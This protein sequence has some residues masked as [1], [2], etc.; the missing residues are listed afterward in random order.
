MADMSAPASLQWERFCRGPILDANGFKV[1]GDYHDRAWTA[2]YPA[3][4]R[5][6]IREDDPRSIAA[7][8]WDSAA[9]V[10]ACR[11]EPG[12]VCGMVKLNEA[13]KPRT[14]CSW[15]R[16]SEQRGAGGSSRGFWEWRTALGPEGAFVS[17]STSF[18]VLTRFAKEELPHLPTRVEPFTVL[19]SAA[20]TKVN[21]DD[22]QFWLLAFLSGRSVVLQA[23]GEALVASVSAVW[24][25]LEP[26]S[27][28]RPYLS[29]G[30]HLDGAYA[31][32]F[33]F[34]TISVGQTGKRVVR[35][36]SDLGEISPGV[37]SMTRRLLEGV[38][39]QSGLEGFAVGPLRTGMLSVTEPRGK[40][41]R[42]QSADLA[43]ALRLKSEVIEGQ[44]FGYLLETTK[45][46]GPQ[47]WADHLKAWPHVRTAAGDAFWARRPER[48]AGHLALAQWA[49]VCTTALAMFDEPSSQTSH[50]REELKWLNWVHLQLRRV[51]PLASAA[52]PIL[53]APFPFDRIRPSWALPNADCL[54]GPQRETEVWLTGFVRSTLNRLRAQDAQLSRGDARRGFADAVYQAAIFWPQAARSAGVQ[55][56]LFEISFWALEHA[57]RDLRFDLQNR[58]QQVILQQNAI[59]LLKAWSELS[60]R[61][62]DLADQTAVLLAAIKQTDTAQLAA[63]R[64]RDRLETLVQTLP[65]DPQIPRLISF[66]TGLSVPLASK[67]RP[68]LRHPVAAL[69]LN[70]PLTSADHIEDALHFSLTP[71]WERRL[72]FQMFRHWPSEQQFANGQRKRWLQ[73]LGKTTSPELYR[74]IA[75]H[76]GGVAGGVT[77]AEIAAAGRANSVLLST[78]IENSLSSPGSD[79]VEVAGEAPPIQLLLEAAQELPS[80]SR[81]ARNLAEWVRPVWNGGIETCFSFGQRTIDPEVAGTALSRCWRLAAAITQL[82]GT[83]PQPRAQMLPKPKV[84]RAVPALWWAI[85]TDVERSLHETAFAEAP[86]DGIAKLLTPLT[87]VK[88][89]MNRVV[90]RTPHTP[91][92]ETLLL[93]REAFAVFLQLSSFRPRS[94]DLRI[95]GRFSETFSSETMLRQPKRALPSAWREAVCETS[96]RFL[97]QGL[98]SGKNG[99]AVSALVPREG[100]DAASWSITLEQFT[101]FVER[102]PDLEDS[103][104][105]A[106]EVFN[107]AILPGRRARSGGAQDT[108][109]IR[110]AYLDSQL[111][112]SA[113]TMSILPAALSKS[114]DLIALESRLRLMILKVVERKRSPRGDS[115]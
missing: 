44:P 85:I 101:L 38:G 89:E 77:A 103:Y 90:G 20:L 100:A 63:R 102:E 98:P 46:D 74:L 41:L 110:A 113:L 37:K 114:P 58:E 53:A 45:R 11:A 33:A 51:T 4:A 42:E 29:F 108:K 86:K 54:S 66:A 68:S 76:S 16:V 60:F 1:A 30:Y 112:F 36:L 82:G 23:D 67:T 48:H 73:H 70:E 7:G 79:S 88:S 99:G 111:R 21:E 56:A 81:G 49:H 78:L 59:Q 52:E 91:E 65:S 92:P 19:T 39:F 32:R 83:I 115:P 84:E 15:H 69:C 104:R 95:L 47:H 2:D 34:S 62:P 35:R 61:E 57:D 93:A 14:F 71:E 40:L 72:A 24:K 17:P 94:L 87:A 18:E 50:V 3:D 106:T 55:Q 12:W 109:A 22:L 64:F 96:A 13:S 27:F 43:L 31:G 28:L 10:T 25:A 80:P 26:A 9:F 97:M 107:L 8:T 5:L 75:S 105:N 6:I